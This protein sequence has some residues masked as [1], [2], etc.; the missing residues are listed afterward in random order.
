LRHRGGARG[1]VAGEQVFD[2]QFRVARDKYARIAVII[3]TFVLVPVLL[4]ILAWYIEGE[5]YSVSRALTVISV[6]VALALVALVAGNVRGR[7]P[8]MLVTAL[9]VAAVVELVLGFVAG[10]GP[11]LWRFVW[12]PWLACPH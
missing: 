2:G 6:L 10:F 8:V 3:A 4:E 9:T 7:L 1:T 12:S 5:E 11:A